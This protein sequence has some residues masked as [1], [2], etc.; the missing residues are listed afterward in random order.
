[1]YE[2]RKEGRG[3][4]RSG[5]LVGSGFDLARLVLLDR[6]EGDVI[7]ELDGL[8]EARRDE[9]AGGKAETGDGEDAL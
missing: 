4:R 5:D 8:E 9:T 3:T 6:L 2:E 7:G 1:L